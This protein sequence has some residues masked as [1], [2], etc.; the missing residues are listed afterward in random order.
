MI[1]ATSGGRLWKCLRGRVI[2]AEIG[3]VS[4]VPAAQGSPGF[5]QIVQYKKLNGH[6]E[7]SRYNLDGVGVRGTASLSLRWRK[8]CPHGAKRHGRGWGWGPRSWRVGAGGWERWD[9][10]SSPLSPQPPTTSYAPPVGMCLTGRSPL[11]SYV[12]CIQAE[13]HPLQGSA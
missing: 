5:W 10:A 3:A 2:A 4:P 1:P 11:A 7:G 13:F 6:L 12:T 9:S 8:S